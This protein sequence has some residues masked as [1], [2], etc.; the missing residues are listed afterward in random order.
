[1]QEGIQCHK[2]K[3][4]APSVYRVTSVYYD[5]VHPIMKDEDG[6]DIPYT[7]LHHG[8]LHEF[9]DLAILPDFVLDDDVCLRAL[10]LK[11]RSSDAD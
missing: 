4:R 11:Y 3:P 10:D 7:E 2:L 9:I 6:R 1:M 8:R 5:L